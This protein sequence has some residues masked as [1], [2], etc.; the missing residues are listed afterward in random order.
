MKEDP[1]QDE[2]RRE[3]RG[4][5]E[6]EVRIAHDLAPR[7]HGRARRGRA[8]RG[9]RA[10]ALDVAPVARRVAFEAPE[11]QRHDRRDHERAARE[12]SLAPAERGDQS[13]AGGRHD[14][15]ARRMAE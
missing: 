9:A 15:L 6:V 2:R 7:P 10:E 8:R 1:R 13:D 5:R 3:R 4:Q 11:D 14:R 12:P